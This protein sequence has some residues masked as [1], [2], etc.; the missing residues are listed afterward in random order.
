MHLQNLLKGVHARP[1]MYGLDGSYP[2]AVNF[3]RGCDFGN[4]FALLRGFREWL[5]VRLG[6]NSS[7]DW[8]AL[9]LRLAFEVEESGRT[10]D[11]VSAEEHRR[12]VD[13]LFALVDG[14]LTDARDPHK[15]AAMYQEYQSLAAH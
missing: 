13:T 3:I 6:Y 14:F 7:L 11:P 4:D 8:S 12:A 10:T 1:G 15:L 2:A 9:C 5:L